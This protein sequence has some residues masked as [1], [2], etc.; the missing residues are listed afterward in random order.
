MQIPKRRAQALKIHESESPYV[1]K[2]KLVRYEAELRDLEKHLRPPVVEELSRAVRMG[3]LS[4][5]AEYQDAKSRLARMD[6]RIFSLKE[7]IKN[8][9]VIDERATDG[10]IRIGSTVTVY[11]EAGAKTYQIVGPQETNPTKGRIS[12]LSPLGSAL[13]NHRAGD[14]VQVN[15]KEFRIERVI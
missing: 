15:G 5:N 2:E 13:L 11:S 9:V 4:E 7:K 12:H 3:D 6:G 10:V 8:A 1:T 14:S